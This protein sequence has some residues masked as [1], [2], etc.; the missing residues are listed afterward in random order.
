MPEGFALVNIGDVNLGNRQTHGLESVVDRHRGVRIG[1]RVDDNGIG[2][3]PGILNPG[4][5]LAFMVG[6]A[7]IDTE[8]A[9]GAGLPA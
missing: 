2:G 8:P 4:D 1:C 7:K 6:L 9:F 3:V 5:Q